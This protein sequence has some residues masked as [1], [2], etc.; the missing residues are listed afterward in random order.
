VLFDWFSLKSSSYAQQIFNIL[1]DKLEAYE[2]Q[3]KFLNKEIL[4]LHSVRLEDEKR[5]QELHT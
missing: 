3:N 2:L 5:M 1:Q 4:E